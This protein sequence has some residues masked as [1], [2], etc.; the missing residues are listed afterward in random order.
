MRLITSHSETRRPSDRDRIVDP[1]W[2]P[3]DDDEG[4]EAALTA[5]MRRIEVSKCSIASSA[6]PANKCSQSLQY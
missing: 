6:C 5:R 4:Q 1:G 2:S 3:A